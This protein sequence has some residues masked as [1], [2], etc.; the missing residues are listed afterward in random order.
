MLLILFPGVCGIGVPGDP[1]WHPLFALCEGH[2][3]GKQVGKYSEVWR[4]I[5]R[6]NR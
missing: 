2:D 4:W 3:I 1:G 5:G 6:I